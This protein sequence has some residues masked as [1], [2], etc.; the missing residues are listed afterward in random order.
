MGERS[1]DVTAKKTILSLSG[2]IK[3]FGSLTAVDEISLVV[4]K[5]HIHGF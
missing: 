2:V 3:R 1:L 5:G 4:Q